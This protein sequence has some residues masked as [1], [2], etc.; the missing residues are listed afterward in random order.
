MSTS[1]SAFRHLAITYANSL[2]TIVNP[3]SPLPPLLQ[4]TNTAETLRTENG[5]LI[6]GIKADITYKIPTLYTDK[7]ESLK[8]LD[9]QG[10]EQLSLEL[11]ANNIGSFPFM[12]N[13]SSI[14]YKLRVTTTEQDTIYQ[15]LPQI[16]E[17]GFIINSEEPAVVIVTSPLS[18]TVYPQGNSL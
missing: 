12:P 13:D 14:S 3:T 17:S 10:N 16:Q 1:G 9:E 5:F 11:T 15:D 8:I 2:I 18:S 4:A 6:K 7:V